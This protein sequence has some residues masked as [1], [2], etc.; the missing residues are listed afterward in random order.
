MSRS[1]YD[2]PFFID[3]GTSLVAVRCQ[4]NMDV[5]Y[6]FDHRIGK[7]GIEMAEKMCDRINAEV[8][9]VMAAKDAEIAKLRELVKELVGGFENWTEKYHPSEWSQMGQ[10]WQLI[11]ETVARAKEGGAK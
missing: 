5:I 11:E 3:V 10:S 6:T 7:Y 4:S 1:N 9:L 2:K 8:E